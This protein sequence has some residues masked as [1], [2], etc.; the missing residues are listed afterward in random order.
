MLNLVKSMVAKARVLR[1]HEKYLRK[2]VEKYGDGDDSR[3]EELH[4]V[5][6]ELAYLD[7][8]IVA[9]VSDQLGPD[10][11]RAVY[12]SYST[13]IMLSPTDPHG[14]VVFSLRHWR[15]ERRSRRAF[16]KNRCDDV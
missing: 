16:R 2:L 10:P 1:R 7:R 4:A 15:D 14:W 6:I 9:A 11:S 12:V 13:A 3:S 8:E 5:E